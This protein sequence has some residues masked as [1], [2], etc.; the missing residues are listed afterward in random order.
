MEYLKLL[1][2]LAKAIAWPVAVLLI[3][4]MFKADVRAL[5][6]RLKKAGPTGFEFDPG[7][8]ALAAPSK[9]LKALPG[10]PERT[11]MIAK[12]ETDLHTEL[13]LIDPEKR[14]DVLI[15]HLAVAR[16]SA[17]FEQI[18]RTLYGTQLRGLRALAA[19]ADGS[20]SRAEA[21]SAFDNQIKPRFAEFYEKNSFDEWVRYLFTVGLVDSKDDKIVITEK[22]R[23]LLRYADAV[24]L[25]DDVRPN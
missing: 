2:E 7:R 3:G 25:S 4:L 16:L 22:G 12:V 13:E 14:T 18:H 24:G 11:P 6:P 21:A 15:R 1:V 5:F 9:E 19:S 20:V 8:Q 17:M 10:F 23:E